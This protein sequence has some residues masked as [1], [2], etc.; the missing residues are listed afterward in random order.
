M[1]SGGKEPPNRFLIKRSLW[2]FGLKKS[3]LY[4]V[5]HQIRES[6][7]ELLREPVFAWLRSWVGFRELLG[8]WS[9]SE[10]DREFRETLQEWPFHSECFFLN[11]ETRGLLED[12]HTHPVSQRPSG[13]FSIYQ[14]VLG[15]LKCGRQGWHNW[16]MVTLGCNGWSW[17]PSHKVQ[18]TRKRERTKGLHLHIG[19]LWGSV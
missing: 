12:S 2:E 16:G 11:L 7:W 4:V 6:L 15:I 8:E 13:P 17:V 14:G 18:V 3:P 5:S 1:R 9:C 10:N 19:G